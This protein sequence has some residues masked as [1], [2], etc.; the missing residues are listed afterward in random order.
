MC[1]NKH[2]LCVYVSKKE[3]ESEKERQLKEND[4]VYYFIS[5]LDSTL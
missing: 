1:F 3:G 4:E 5:H 2:Y